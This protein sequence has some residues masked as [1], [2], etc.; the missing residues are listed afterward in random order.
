MTASIEAIATV[1]QAQPS[2]V[3][4]PSSFLLLGCGILGLIG[5]SRRKVLARI[6]A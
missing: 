5:I 6:A 2:A 4:E 1:D 3:P